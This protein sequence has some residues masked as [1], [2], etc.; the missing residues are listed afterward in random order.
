MNGLRYVK[1]KIRNFFPEIIWK[2]SV[3]LGQ[4]LRAKAFW[5]IGVSIFVISQSGF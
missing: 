4:K 3:L 2:R 5:T 1:L